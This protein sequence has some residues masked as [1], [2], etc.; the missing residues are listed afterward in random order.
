MET[1]LYALDG[2]P[3]CEAVHD[4]LQTADIDYETN[5]VEPLHSDRDEV[6]RVSGQRAVPVLVDEERG[7]TMAESENILQYIDQT[8]A[9]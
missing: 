5:W 7:V 3:Y 2:C 4:A 1:V 6:K 9:Q 8:L